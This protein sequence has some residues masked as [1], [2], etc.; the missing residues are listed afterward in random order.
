MLDRK[1]KILVFLLFVVVLVNSIIHFNHPAYK[2]YRENVKQFRSDYND[3]VRQVRL[4]LVPSILMVAS[5]NNNSVSSLVSPAL[6]PSVSS[7]SSAASSSSSDSFLDCRFFKTGGRSYIEYNNNY[8]TDG[9]DFFG[10]TILE[11]RPTIVITDGRVFVI[12]PTVRNNQSV[13]TS[14]KNQSQIT[15]PKKSPFSLL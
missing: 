14:Q 6:L 5:N 4:E 9:D 2:F 7:S 12:R 8:F 11:V 1:F 13:S 10:Y 15:Q 3:F